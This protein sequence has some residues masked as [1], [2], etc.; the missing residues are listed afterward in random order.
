MRSIIFI[1]IKMK[2][3]LYPTPLTLTLPHTSGGGTTQFFCAI[4]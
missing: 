2:R 4:F 1:S 3:V